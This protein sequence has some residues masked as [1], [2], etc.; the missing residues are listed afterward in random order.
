[1]AVAE[2]PVRVSVSRRDGSVH[3][4]WAEGSDAQLRQVVQLLIRAG[5]AVLAYEK[6]GRSCNCD[7]ATEK[8]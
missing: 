8:K 2:I 6:T 4:Q 5:E 7:P 3:I 1:M